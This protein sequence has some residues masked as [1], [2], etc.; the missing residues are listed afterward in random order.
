LLD[1]QAEIIKQDIKKDFEQFITSI[2]IPDI[3]ICLTLDWR[4]SWEWS[5]NSGKEEY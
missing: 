4:S 3:P 2:G 1:R 5:K